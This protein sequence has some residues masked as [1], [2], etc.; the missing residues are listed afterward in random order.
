MKKTFCVLFLAISLF[1]C[2][3]SPVLGTTQQRIKDSVD[4]VSSNWILRAQKDSLKLVIAHKDSIL[5]EC[6]CLH[7]VK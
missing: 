4:V 7:T 5:D 3:C 1:S 6:G 2:R